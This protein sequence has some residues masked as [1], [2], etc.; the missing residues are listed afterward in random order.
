MYSVVVPLPHP[1]ST[2]AP[3]GTIAPDCTAATS[4]ETGE[5]LS[6]GGGADPL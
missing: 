1:T 4:W 5:P 2:A 6:Q 3:P